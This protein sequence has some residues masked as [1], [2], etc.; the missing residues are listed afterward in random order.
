MN[1]T[2]SDAAW[3]TEHFMCWKFVVTRK[4]TERQYF[5]VANTIFSLFDTVN[6]KAMQYNMRHCTLCRHLINNM[7]INANNY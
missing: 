5:E 6:V 2:L 7:L 3:V 4:V 1:I